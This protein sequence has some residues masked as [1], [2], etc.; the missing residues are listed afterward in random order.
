MKNII[1]YI[2]LG[3][4]F[5]SCKKIIE[6]DTNNAEPQIVI[7]G[8]ISN[9][10]ASQQI[11]IS[12]SVGYDGLNN[13]PKVSGAKVVVTDNR[14]NTYNFTE[15][16]PG[17]Y[18]FGMRG[19]SGVTYTMQVEAEGKTYTAVSKMPGYV[20][21]DS[22]GVVKNTFFGNENLNIAAFVSD[23]VNTE[24]FYRFNL[25]VND[26]LS[27]RIYVNNDRL[28]N[29]NKLRLQLYYEG[30]NDEDLK[31][32]DKVSVEMQCIDSNIFD[33][34]YALS[35]QSGRGPNQGT[36][37]ANP[38]SNISN[39]ALGYFSAHTYQRLNITVP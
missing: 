22:I 21:M 13:F 35:Q 26:N 23:P 6:V 31:K 29:G 18:V 19:T 36:T 8:N 7:E 4:I 9:R 3:L 28:T 10:L 39:G 1:L 11:K 15:S 37:P 14:G 2:F 16:Q 24:N 17:L 12:K 25:Y 30:A 38:T 33:Y 27:D 34:W 32:G 20:P 5:T